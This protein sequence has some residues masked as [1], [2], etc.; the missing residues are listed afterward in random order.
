MIERLQADAIVAIS[1]VTLRE[2]NEIILIK[3]EKK[4]KDEVQPI[5]DLNVKSAKKALSTKAS[6]R[7]WIWILAVTV[8][9]ISRI[10][11]LM[12]NKAPEEF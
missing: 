8:S 1:D 3:D 2:N 7:N 5:Q 6:F 11:F 10:Y 9:L 4:E 12:L